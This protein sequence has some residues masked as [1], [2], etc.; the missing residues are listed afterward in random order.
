MTKKRLNLFFQTKDCSNEKYRQDFDAYVA[1]IKS[2]G[3]TTEYE[4]GLVEEEL[5]IQPKT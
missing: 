2:Y 3:G 1:T 5:K 4:D